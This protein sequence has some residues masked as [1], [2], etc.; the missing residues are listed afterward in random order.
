[1]SKRKLFEILVRERY[2]ELCWFVVGMLRRRGYSASRAHE[3]AGDIVAETF[4]TA[5]QN[6]NKYDPGRG[7]FRQWIKG[8][9]AN[10]IQESLRA[11]SQ[12]ERH[13][14][15]MAEEDAL[16]LPLEMLIASNSTFDSCRQ[17]LEACLEAL[18]PRD[19]GIIHLRYV[20]GLNCVA[21]AA[22]EQMAPDA[23]RQKIR[24]TLGRLRECIRRK[25]QQEEGH[26]A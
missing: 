20:G 15:H 21:I 4:L 14:N 1:M 24:R 11:A 7:E 22:Q 26:D 5:W 13:R 10:K 2:G 19:R 16:S 6:Q 23:I 25:H 8:I 12:E 18:A 3:L 17:F 9:A